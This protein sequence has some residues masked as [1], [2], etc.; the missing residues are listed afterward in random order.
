MV[1]WLVE[2]RLAYRETLADGFWSEIRTLDLTQVPF[3][4][5]FAALASRLAG[6]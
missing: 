6:R 5:A 4:D 1:G 2:N 3:G